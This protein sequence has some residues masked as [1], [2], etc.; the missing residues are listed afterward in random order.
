M[1]L[2][3]CC[4]VWIWCRMQHEWFAYCKFN[5]SG[6]KCW[7][8]LHTLKYPIQY[9][10]KQKTCNYLR[11]RILVAYPMLSDYICI[12][13]AY[14]SIIL[15]FICGLLLVTGFTP[16]KLPTCM[17]L[18]ICWSY[19]HGLWVWVNCNLQF[20]NQKQTVFWMICQTST[21]IESRIRLSCTETLETTNEPKSRRVSKTCEQ[22]LQPDLLTQSLAPHV[23]LG[24]WNAAVATGW[25]KA[26]EILLCFSIQRKS[27]L[28][29]KGDGYRPGLRN[30]F[31]LKELSSTGSFLSILL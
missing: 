26:S 15:C 21:I 11:S 8:L 23:S 7:Y 13:L 27:N 22:L 3:K 28:Y 19:V 12:V 2:K 9:W 17:V 5:N 6:T 24:H 31:A 16:Q 20:P 4:F 14:T 1:Y 18:L 29:V 30:R 10:K 25:V